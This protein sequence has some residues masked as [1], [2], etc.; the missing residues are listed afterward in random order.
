MGH[1]QSQAAVHACVLAAGTSTRFGATK[2]VRHFRGKPLVQHSLLA[3]Q[4]ACKGCVTLVVGHDEE[5][6]IAASAG[7]G[8]NVIV[9]REHQLGIGTSIA[10]GT[11][12]CRDGADAILIVLADQALVTAA[13]LKKL[14]DN[15]SGADDEIIASSFAGIVGPPIL[16][17]KHAFDT[18]CNL[19]GDTGAKKILSNDEFHVRSIDFPPAGLDVDTPEDLRNLDQA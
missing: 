4:G 18:L 6:V 10:A 3:A 9:N 5:A 2:L 8:D 16:F 11:R 14:I 12:A 7:L 1:H 13:H 15:W 17:P 19:S